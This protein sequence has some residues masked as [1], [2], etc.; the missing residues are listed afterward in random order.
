MALAAVVKV[1]Y[2]LTGG[3]LRQ[4]GPKVWEQ[5]WGSWGGEGSE[6]LPTS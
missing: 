3:S 1:V 4:L 2:A 6:P 5:G